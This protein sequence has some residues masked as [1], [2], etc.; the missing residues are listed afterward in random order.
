MRNAA[1]MIWCPGPG[2]NWT[3]AE[4]CGGSGETGDEQYTLVPWRDAAWRPGMYLGF[5]SYLNTT[6]GGVYSVRNE[7]LSS[8]D[9]GRT[10]TR[11]APRQAFIPF[12]TGTPITPSIIFWFCR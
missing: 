7:L 12:G 4:A 10:W 6:D 2:S 5:G 9:Y 1:L 11:V 3:R 8:G